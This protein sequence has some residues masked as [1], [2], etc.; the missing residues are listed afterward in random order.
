MK[1]AL[2][3]LQSQTICYWQ[4]AGFEPK[5]RG[6]VHIFTIHRDKS[7]CFNMSRRVPKIQCFVHHLYMYQSFLCL[8]VFFPFKSI[9]VCV[10]EVSKI[11]A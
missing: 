8:K 7:T 2:Q 11:Q 10:N 9:A 1:F 5:Q 3:S 4:N 6:V